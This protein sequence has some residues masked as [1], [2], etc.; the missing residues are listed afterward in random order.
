[1]PRVRE[2]TKPSMAADQLQGFWETLPT[3]NDVGTCKNG[4]GREKGS[5]LEE[6]YPPHDL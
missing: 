4:V 3:L 5:V 1:M 6:F 2:S